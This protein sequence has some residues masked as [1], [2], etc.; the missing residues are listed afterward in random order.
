MIRVLHS[1]HLYFDH[2]SLLIS[3]DVSMIFGL[4][5][6]SR[7]RTIT[8]RNSHK[9]KAYLQALIVRIPLV[10]KFNNLYYENPNKNELLFLLAKLARIHGNACYNATGSV[11]SVLCSTF[12]T[13][14]GARDLKNL[15]DITKTC[16]GFQLFSK[17]PSRY[18]IILPE[19]GVFN[20][21]VAFDIMFI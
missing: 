18:R 7:L 3:K 13:K 14:A 9:S 6:Q 1:G 15:Q 5:T 19:K 10:F 17:R 4:A 20:F 11:Y 16:K 2:S 8:H 21:D 12:K